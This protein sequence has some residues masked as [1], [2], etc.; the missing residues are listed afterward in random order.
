MDLPDF[1]HLRVHSAY[2]LSEGAIKIPDLVAL[3]KE[4]AM[5]AVALTDSGNLFG[6]LEFSIAACKA[7][8]QPIIGCQ[9]LVDRPVDCGETAHL[10]ANGSQSAYDN[11]ILLAQNQI[12]YRNL[13]KLASLSF[14]GT[15]PEEKA[16]IR[17]DDLSEYTEGLIALTGGFSGGLGRLLA[18]G[19]DSA[20]NI[21]AEKL[22][23]L[24]PGRLY[25]E[26][27]RHGWPTD[28]RVDAALIDLA[29][30]RNLPVVATNDCHF[31]DSSMFEAH[32]ALL[33]IAD[34]AHIDQEDRRRL[35]P[36]HGFRSQSEMVEAFADIPE[37][38]T[39]TVVIAQRCAFMPE[40]HPPMLPAFPTVGGMSEADQ[41]EADAKDGLNIRLKDLG[42]SDSEAEPYRDR[43]N[44]ELG[45]IN[46]MGFPG[47]FLIVADFIQ[48]AK[49]QGIP[50][51]PGRGS[52]A[53][54]VVAWALTI[55]DL[56]PLQ[57][58]LLFERFLNPERVSMPD[59]D[60]DFCQDRRDEVIRYVQEKYGDERVAQIITFGKLQARA[61]LRD[62]GR[63]LGMP[64]G[65]VDRICKLIPFNPAHPPTLQEALDGEP[66]LRRLRDEDEQVA[67]LL[68]IGLKLEGLYRHASTHAAGV[69][70][71]D[72]ALDEFVPL[73]RDPRSDMAATQFSMKY[74]EAAGLVKFDFLGLKTL[75]VLDRAVE[76]LEQGGISFDLATLPLNDEKTFEMLGKGDTV[77]VFQLESTGM[78]DVLRQMKPDCFEDI[79]ALVALY[80]PGPMDNIPRYIACK[81]GHEEPDYL[82]PDLE[83]I[84]TETFGVMI[85]QEQVMQIAQVLSGFTLGNADLLRRAMG[86]KIKSEMEAQRNIFVEGAIARGV[87][88][89]QAAQIFDQVDKFAGYGFNKSHAAAY[90]LV[91]YQTAWLKANHPVEFLAASMTLDM[92]NTDKLKVFKDEL[93]SLDIELLPPE[94]NESDAYFSVRQPI[95]GEERGAVRYALAAIKNVGVQAMETLVGER[96][97]NGPY[98][99]VFEFAERVGIKVVNKRLIENLIRAGAF[100]ALESNRRKLLEGV[101]TIIKT[102]SAAERERADQQESL[103]GGDKNLLATQRQ[104][105][106]DIEDWPKIERLGEEADAIGFF[107]SE[108]PMDS[109]G[110]A[111]DRLSVVPHT[112]LTSASAGTRPKLAGIVESKRER[113]S[114]KGNKFAFVE[115]SSRDGGFEV[116]VFSEVLAASRELLEQGQPVLLTCD[117]RVEGNDVKLNAVTISDLNAAVANA[118]AGL[119]VHINSEN[120]FEALKQALD[121]GKQGHGQVRL[122]LDIDQMQTVELALPGNYLISPDIRSMIESVPGVTELRDI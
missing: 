68:D 53:G 38:I 121:R 30:S 111:L 71:G 19:Q 100:E 114:A 70:I 25:V 37:A 106:P 108:H 67:R 120:S 113:T 63:V 10:R 118:G 49:N 35:T 11:L 31:S 122:V 115:L 54:S 28:D 15:L 9:I 7:G 27:M 47:Y 64:Y 14:L 94:I 88:G 20:A 39:N 97:T 65:Y 110:G 86:K 4:H 91:A 76:L 83:G 104:S 61:V 24:F 17:F 77:G 85:Y 33:C 59:F 22:E 99:D 32:D 98:A 43:L 57:F 96:N 112:S 23:T 117:V 72:Q 107:L 79:I 1:I 75:T 48:W 3:C 73:Y 41:L 52:G 87:D 50:V 62:V 13:V 21:L 6:A 58:G 42:I 16:H 92:G 18:D 40:E 5:P 119:K 69:V 60:I 82:H 74:A 44:F 116:V 55:T 80:R 103:F 51:G 105:L 45:V 89:A 8:L 90:A 95:Q 2:S 102:A 66:E 26:L 81:H 78:R 29:Y 34:G 36:L 93:Q 46:D 101:E 12:G 109:Y 84:L 56:D